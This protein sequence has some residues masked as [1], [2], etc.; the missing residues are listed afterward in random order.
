MDWRDL[1][2]FGTP[3]EK[4]K[5]DISFGLA[6][7]IDNAITSWLM[8]Q[9]SQIT[10]L[11]FQLILDVPLQFFETKNFKLLYFLCSS[12]VWSI[13]TPIIIYHGFKLIA[14][15][16]TIYD[17]GSHLFR[18]TLCPFAVWLAPIIIKTILL[19]VNRICRLLLSITNE[20]VFIRPETIGLG[21]IIFV[22]IMIYY[23]FKLSIYYA[24]RNV[25]I[26]FLVV[27]FPLI[28]LL[29]CMPSKFDKLD[30]YISEL[31]ALILTQF[32]H[33]I[34]L[35]ILFALTEIQSDNLTEIMLRI[36][37]L[38]VMLNAPNWLEGYL[39]TRIKGVSDINVNREI[40]FA[41]KTVGYIT[42]PTKAIKG[43]F[44]VFKR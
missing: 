7:K 24:G 25:L 35:L 18:L 41:K 12:I 36:G 23:L 20:E 9:M 3:N 43:V 42:N 5:L 33:V 6:D 11:F 32:V 19:I 31:S 28:F 2:N 1:L 30:K 40:Q 14:G 16:I 37:A 13:V 10:T 22:G 26:I 34:Q 39:D 38:W 4:I 8:E 15:K 44:D 27:V 21:T 17:M 29:S